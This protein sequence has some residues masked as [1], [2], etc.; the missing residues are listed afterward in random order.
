[1]RLRIVWNYPALATFYDL[2][3]HEATVLDRAVIRFAET[4]EG[5]LEW[6]PPHHRLRTG[7]HDAMLDIDTETRVVTVLRIYRASI[8]Q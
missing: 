6:D 7:A 3:V 8:R 1:V 2:R 4:G 5:D